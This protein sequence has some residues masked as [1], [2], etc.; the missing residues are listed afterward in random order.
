MLKDRKCYYSLSHSMFYYEMRLSVAYLVPCSFRGQT[1]CILWLQGLLFYTENGEKDSY[2]DQL[3]LKESGVWLRNVS[4]CLI[5]NVIHTYIRNNRCTRR[6]RA[7]AP[8]DKHTANNWPFGNNSQH[9]AGTGCESSCP[10]KAA[11]R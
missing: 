5:E 7:H 11:K 9:V 8:A 1:N 2:L 4:T 3:E 6:T 10:R